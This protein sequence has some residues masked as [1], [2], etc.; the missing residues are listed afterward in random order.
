MPTRD[1]PEHFLKPLVTD[2]DGVATLLGTTRDVV[3]QTM[4]EGKLP[5][6]LHVCG[7]EVWG[8][9]EIAEWVK[10]GAPDRQAWERI[11]AMGRSRPA[12]SA[13]THTTYRYNPF[14]IPRAGKGVYGWARDM[15]K[16]FAIS[17]IPGMRRDS[18]KLGWGKVFSAWNQEQVDLLCMCVVARICF[19][20]DYQGQ[21]DHL[22]QAH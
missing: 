16:V 3:L 1:T 7:A 4:R 17:I 21:F 5:S 10:A 8:I 14:Q 15:E 6:P 20:P 18:Q 19:L 9:E 2:L 11:K 12:S 13:I 22:F